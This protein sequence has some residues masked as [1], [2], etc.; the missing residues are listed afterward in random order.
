MVG[1]GQLSLTEVDPTSGSEQTGLIEEELDCYGVP[2]H[3]R[4]K[5]YKNRELVESNAAC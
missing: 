2:V 4:K 5:A 1:N 3:L